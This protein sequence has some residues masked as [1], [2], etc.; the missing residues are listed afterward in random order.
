VVFVTARKGKAGG[1]DKNGLYLKGVIW[2]SGV[3]HLKLE[4]IVA[5]TRQR[6][7]HAAAERR[8]TGSDHVI[9]QGPN[10]AGRATAPPDFD[11]YMAPFC[12]LEMR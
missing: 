3:P 9:C 4:L 1:G 2:K 8:T 12:T 5:V 11:Q 10:V 6:Y 7:A